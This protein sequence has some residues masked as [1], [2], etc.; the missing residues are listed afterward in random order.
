[1][2]DLIFEWM[3]MPDRLIAPDIVRGRPRRLELILVGLVAGVALALPL[4]ASLLTLELLA[5]LIAMLGVLAV[6]TY[7]NMPLACFAALAITAWCSRTVLDFLGANI[8]VEQPAV[9]ILAAWLLWRHH[10]LIL[11]LS[12]RHVVAITGIAVWLAAMFVSSYFIAPDRG[13][14]LR[15]EAWLCASILS[16]GVAAVLAMRLRTDLDAGAVF[17]A[18]ALVQVCVALLALVT[19]RLFGLTWGGFFLVNGSGIFRAFAL[20]WEPN[21]FGSGIAIVVPFAIDRYV[22]LRRWIDLIPVGL[23]SLGLGFALTRAAWIAV[24]AGLV[25]YVCILA[26]RERSFVIQR[27][28]LV[29]AGLSIVVLGALLGVFLTAWAPA[30]SAGLLAQRAQE[31]ET[32]QVPALAIGVA[33]PTPSSGPAPSSGPTPGVPAIP[34]DLGSDVNISYRL[35]RAAQALRDLLRSPVIGMGANS[36]GQR[37]LDKSEPPQPDYVSTFPITVV[38]DA[39]LVGAAGFCIFVLAMVMALW[40]STNRRLA[41]PYLASMVVMAVA[42]V[43]TDALRFSQNWLIFGAALGLACRPMLSREGDSG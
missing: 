40:R 32:I 15:I 9:V 22:R 8:R 39:G 17:V 36:Y 37:H 26:F 7:R 29:Y 12:R 21:I 3:T 20:A 35:E 27:I 6:L 19:G 4:L 42:Y 14:S 2:I 33:G 1:L 38:Y 34:V 24:V 28:R 11:Q 13:A 43:S 30:G 10:A 18:A 31:P 5:A 41:A 25:C 23:L 16:A